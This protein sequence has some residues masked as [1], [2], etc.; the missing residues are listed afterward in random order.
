MEFLYMENELEFISWWMWS[1]GYKPCYNNST[2]HIALLFDDALEGGDGI[3]LHNCL[4]NEAF[5]RIV[6]PYGA[7]D[8]DKKIHC[9]Q[10]NHCNNYIIIV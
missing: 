3:I 6:P 9:S 8:L 10:V 2:T 4:Q 1:C 5:Q 7:I